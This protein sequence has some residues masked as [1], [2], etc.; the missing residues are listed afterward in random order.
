MYLH[1]CTKEWTTDAHNMDKT[2]KH[3]TV[4]KKPKMH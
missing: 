1:N 3:H 4:Q 2:Q